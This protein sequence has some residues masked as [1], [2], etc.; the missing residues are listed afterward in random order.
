EQFVA[1]CPVTSTL[2]QNLAE[3]NFI[4]GVGVLRM[5][6]GCQLPYHRDYSPFVF[7]YHLPIVVPEGPGSCAITVG[8]TR[9]DF[10]EGVGV[11]FDSNK[12]HSAEN[13]RSSARTNLVIDVVRN[14]ARMY[15]LLVGI[16]WALAPVIRRLGRPVRMTSAMYQNRGA[17]LHR[18]VS[19]VCEAETRPSLKLARTLIM[20]VLHGRRDVQRL[21]ATAG[22]LFADTALGSAQKRHWLGLACTAVYA[23]R[24]GLYVLTMLPKARIEHC[25]SMVRYCLEQAVAGD[26]VEAG[27]WRGG[28]AAVMRRAADIYGGGLRKVWLLDSF[29]GMSDKVDNSL[30][31]TG[32][33]D[34][35]DAAC[36]KLLAHIEQEMKCPGIFVASEKEVR[37]NLQELG[38][39]D[40]CNIVKG[41]LGADYPWSE[42]PEVIALLRLDVDLYEPTYACLERLYPRVSV[43]GAILLDEYYLQFCGERAAVDDYRTRH[44]ITEPIIRV[45]GNSAMW[46]KRSL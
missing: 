44:A 41:W 2:L 37:E 43:G 3:K 42:M 39:L 1:V 22:E 21:L 32:L 35:N 10:V 23:Q 26:F 45:D 25:V 27:V 11:I 18:F 20:K 16:T 17:T 31:R 14:D 38:V 12:P 30:S 19:R 33:H 7:R 9:T 13:L 8:N 4:P 34:K 29:E 24:A 36:L 46:I 28:S 40:G 5:K 6:A 15:S